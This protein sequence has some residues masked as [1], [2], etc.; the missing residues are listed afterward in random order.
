MP[1]EILQDIIDEL[2]DKLG[3][4]GAHPDDDSDAECDCRVCF[5]SS[6]ND[7]I[8]SAVRTE[9]ALEAGRKL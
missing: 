7:R 5:T 4:Y 8:W 2:A 6:L 1:L 9:Q 3:I